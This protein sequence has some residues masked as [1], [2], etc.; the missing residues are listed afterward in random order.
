MAAPKNFYTPPTSSSSS[1]L[2]YDAAGSRNE[3][4]EYYPSHAQA[5]PKGLAGTDPKRLERLEQRMMTRAEDGSAPYPNA[6]PNK[7]R[8]AEMNP[9]A[10]FELTGVRHAVV[11][12][13]QG[14]I[15]IKIREFVQKKDRD[16][17]SSPRGIN[18]RVNEWK[19]LVELMPAITEAV[20]ELENQG[21]KKMK[22]DGDAQSDEATP[23][24]EDG[25]PWGYTGDAVPYTKPS[26]TPEEQKEREACK[27][28]AF[29]IIQSIFVPC[30]LKKV[31]EMC[32]EQCYGCNL[33]IAEDFTQ[34]NHEC[35]MLDV[36]DKVERYFDKAVDD[37]LETGLGKCRLEWNTT[38][39][40]NKRIVSQYS[41][42]HA[43]NRLFTKYVDM[44]VKKRVEEPENGR[45]VLYNICHIDG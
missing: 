18:L 8:R 5:Q 22:R 27:D 19:K 17:W 15:Y 12:P 24:P 38:A 11:E 39:K 9:S 42:I 43:R 20:E 40:E 21:S 29:N 37:I 31:D 36:S 30:I 6:A 23:D 2:Q 25:F 7:S 33:P 16:F 14:Q 41:T 13:F 28:L 45:A 35:L 3:V 32:S 44:H 34:K 1:S 26:G 4:R 10:R